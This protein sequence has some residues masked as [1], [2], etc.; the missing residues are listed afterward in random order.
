[1]RKLRQSFG[2]FLSRF[3]FGRILSLMLVL[4]ILA[5]C[6]VFLTQM[7]MGIYSET[8]AEF[9]DSQQKVLHQATYVLESVVD[10][11]N[12]S[13]AYIFLST[14]VKNHIKAMRGAD[15]A[16]AFFARQDLR[17]FLG[18]ISTTLYTIRG[19]LAI[20][21]PDGTM[22]LTGAINK[23]GKALTD[24]DWYAEVARRRGLPY[25]DSSIAAIYGISAGEDNPGIACAR[26]LLSNTNEVMGIVTVFIPNASL[27]AKINAL[28]LRYRGNMYF[29]S[30]A[31][32]ILARDMHDLN[33]R[34]GF[35][36]E[37]ISGL[38]A[39][40]VRT[41]QKISV[42]SDLQVFLFPVGKTDFYLVNEISQKTMLASVSG[43]ISRT[44]V[45]ISLVF[46][47]FFL[48]TVFIARFT[49][50]PI[51]RLTA[52]IDR[53]AKGDLNQRAVPQGAVELCRLSDSFNV[54]AGRMLQLIKDVEKQAVLREEAH[55][56]MLRAQIQP[57]F[58]F[59]SL[60]D[61]RWMAMLN[62]VD[63]VANAIEQLGTIL[64]STLN[65]ADH[66][67]T[68]AKELETLEA[69]VRLQKMRYGDM[70][71]FRVLIPKELM[72][73]VIPKFILQPIV[74]NAIFHGVSGKLDGVITADAA[75]RGQDLEI[76]I[77]DNGD[78]VPKE[79][80][81]RLLVS[82]AAPD[83]R[84]YVS[85]LGIRNIHERLQIQF[86]SAYGLTLQSGQAAGFTVIIRLPATRVGSEAHDV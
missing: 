16:A 64:S 32:A 14:E 49:T 50:R 20:V 57:H 40:G 77:S 85:G 76:V 17:K 2:R 27:W 53:M 74:E 45:L 59:N 11:V 52:A 18:T 48:M 35:G 38:I 78:G 26:A 61:I 82:D 81:A 19:E 86:G 75:L 47:A 79:Q 55:F 70:F 80:L 68:I 22:L 71:E 34:S 12:A 43:S 33:G 63:S 29:V 25:W 46:V 28:D 66:T 69:Y 13:S 4:L 83:S 10:T 30:S 41:V 37:R 73:Y 39:Q 58:L 84:K 24:F 5:P 31:N 21:L 72:D 8:A 54:M 44:L 7:F 36:V 56:N 42:N 1:M 62:G 60:N 6:Y 67:A 23:L 9:M 65:T 15:E 3:T 51:V